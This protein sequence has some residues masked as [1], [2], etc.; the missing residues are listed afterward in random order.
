MHIQKHIK[1]TTRPSSQLLASKECR[2]SARDQYLK[3]GVPRW[4]ELR[5]VETKPTRATPH[6]GAHE[7]DCAIV[8]K[9][10]HNPCRHAVLSWKNYMPCMRR[11][12]TCPMYWVNPPPNAS[13]NGRIKHRV[14][15]DSHHTTR[16]LCD[17]YLLVFLVYFWATEFFG[18]SPRVSYTI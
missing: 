5:A 15:P 8:I 11:H 12:S 1:A 2:L 14:S 7:N 16:S 10:Q 9:K 6:L 4:G 13:A 18:V 3:R 17:I